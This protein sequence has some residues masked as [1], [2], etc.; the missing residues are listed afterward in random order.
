MVTPRM[1]EYPPVVFCS[2]ACARGFNP[3]PTQPTT[4]LNSLRYP[5]WVGDNK[6]SP[7]KADAEISSR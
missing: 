5:C 2:S 6:G 4:T 7:G 1:T 3:L